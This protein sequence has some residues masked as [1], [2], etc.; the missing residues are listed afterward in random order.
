MVSPTMTIP[1]RA[2]RAGDEGRVE[3]ATIV[4]ALSARYVVATV[5]SRLVRCV[6]LDT[7]DRRLRRAD[8]TLE[9][10]RTA[11]YARVVVGMSDAAALVGTPAKGQRWPAHADVLPQGPI[12]DAVAPVAGIRALMVVSD[13]KRRMVRLDLRNEDG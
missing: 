13:E 7:F 10:Q 3:L 6:Q 12:R 1:V 2:L 9:H 11:S 4:S 5:S 8:L